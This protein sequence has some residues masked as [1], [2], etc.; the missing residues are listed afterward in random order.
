MN[1]HFDLSN[2][3]KLVLALLA[4]AHV[5]MA[6]H[7]LVQPMESISLASLLP[8]SRRVHLSDGCQVMHTCNLNGVPA[9][10]LS[11]HTFVFRVNLHLQHAQAFVISLSCLLQAQHLR[12]T[13]W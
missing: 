7:K 6:L 8:L 12:P 1:G 4:D 2:P 13:C 3:A 10:T 9:T 5:Q 11:A